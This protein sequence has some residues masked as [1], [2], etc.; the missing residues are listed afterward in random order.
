MP[1]PEEPK[2]PNPPENGATPEQKPA[3]ENQGDQPPSASEA[4][5]GETHTSY[6]QTVDDPYNYYDDPYHAD[7]HQ[8]EVLPEPSVPAPLAAAP[9]PPGPPK[10]PKEE[11]KEEEDE[12]D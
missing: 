12:D 1:S 11:P 4:A 6:S 2:G 3:L 7:V 8:T 5:S 9:P 10:P